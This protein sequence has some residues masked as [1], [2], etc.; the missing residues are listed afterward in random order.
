M[1]LM[2]QSTSYATLK[3]KYRDFA[4]PTVRIEVEGKDLIESCHAEI[5][6]VE[7][8]L[9]CEYPA[10]G[11]SFD[12][13]GEY[14]F[15]NSDF[16]QKGAASLLELGAKVTVSLGYIA[17]EMVFYGL[18]TEV[19]Y[20]FE[21]HT[22]PYI[23]VECMDAKC[24]LMKTQRLEICKETSISSAVSALLSSQPVGSYLKGKKIEVMSKNDQPITINMESCYDFV[25]RQAQYAGMEFFILCGKAYFRKQ[26]TAGQP[27]MTLSFGQGLLDASL[28]LNGAELVEQVKVVGIDPT[29]DKEVSGVAKAV[30]KFSKGSTAKQ[31]ISGTQRVYLDASS[32]T[33]EQAK[34]RATTLMNGIQHRFGRLECRCEGLPDLVPGRMVKIAGVMGLADTNYYI[35]NVRHR[36]DESGFNTYIEARIDHL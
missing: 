28:T 21:E 36:V 3:N 12:V 34:A 6:N 8:D 29:T 9:T 27:I 13:S 1:D 33:A 2:L 10:S 26:P 11:C 19:T 24:L 25:V 17:T 5:S 15:S 4:A 14:V 35:T 23:H 18:I 32:Q 31:M 22:A 30:G 7:V 20:R 16:D